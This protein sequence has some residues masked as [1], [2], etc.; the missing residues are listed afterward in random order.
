MENA[1]ELVRGNHPQHWRALKER[2]EDLGYG[3]SVDIHV[4]SRFGLPQVRERA[5]V[6]ASRLGAPRSLS[7]MW[8]GWDVLPGAITVRHALDRLGEWGQPDPT[9]SVFPSM[10]PSV[11]A[12]LRA[13]PKDGGGWVDVAANPATRSL[14]TPQCLARWKEGKTGSHP[15][16][17]GR[18]WWDRPA[19]TI[20]RECAHIGNG[21][22]AHPDL[23][24]LL[25][26]REMAT[27]QGFPFTYQFP[28][29]AISNRYRVIGDAVPPLIAR[30][31]AAACQWTRTGK[32]PDPQEWILPH[33]TLRLSDLRRSGR[34]A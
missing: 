22:Y 6:I 10:S 32:R 8:E 5:L 3:V 27:V 21:R 23:D 12:R 33:T 26:V 15:D 1:R 11:L 7:E 17:Y 31:I 28:S 20:K 25:T 4:L 29:P 13:T 30:Q 34:P 19:P 24:R 18:M 9:G 2:L 16:V 14:S